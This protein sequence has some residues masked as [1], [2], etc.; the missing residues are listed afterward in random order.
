MF[1]LIKKML[2][3]RLRKILCYKDN[4]VMV[5]YRRDNYVVFLFRFD[6]F[7]LF[8][9]QQEIEKGFRVNTLLDLLTI[10]VPRLLRSYHI[11]F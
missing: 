4:L 2:D 5:L 3:L 1:N 7:I 10:G 9:C 8:F 11:V 6:N